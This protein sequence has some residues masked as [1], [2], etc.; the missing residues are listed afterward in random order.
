LI[1]LALTSRIEGRKLAEYQALGRAI[2]IGLERA[3]ESFSARLDAVTDPETFVAF[4]RALHATAFASVPFGGVFAKKPV[5]VD[6]GP[7]EFFG[8]AD[9]EGALKSLYTRVGLEPR[10]EQQEVAAWAARFLYGYCRIHPFSDGNGR[11]ARL[12]VQLVLAQRTPFRFVPQPSRKTNR[13]YLWALRHA[14]KHK[15]VSRASETVVEVKPA[16]VY[17]ERWLSKQLIDVRT[18]TTEEPPEWG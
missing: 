17:L 14:H 5:A 2:A 15:G 6:N 11:T 1:D 3:R 10:G 9:V 7:H 4:V 16:F 8:E 12:I 18:V 13:A